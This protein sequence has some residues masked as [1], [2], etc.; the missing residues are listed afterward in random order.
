MRSCSKA[1]AK[2]RKFL[3][4]LSTLLLFA[5]KTA[6]SVP[7]AGSLLKGEEDIKNYKKIPRSLP[8][9]DKPKSKKI[10]PQTDGSADWPGDNHYYKLKQ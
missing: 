4:T 8:K 1:K 9:I 3:I 2:K 10:E 7:D 5:S 6:N